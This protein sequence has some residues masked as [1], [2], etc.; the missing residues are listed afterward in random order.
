VFILNLTFEILSLNPMYMYRLARQLRICLLGI[1]KFPFPK[2]RL[3]V[4]VSTVAVYDKASDQQ[5]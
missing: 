5:M 4:A 3:N 1:E 2:N